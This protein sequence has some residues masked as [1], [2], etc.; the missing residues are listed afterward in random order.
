MVI[1][2]P[3]Q[4]AHRHPIHLIQAQRQSHW[5]PQGLVPIGKASGRNYRREKNRSEIAVAGINETG[6]QN[7]VPVSK[8]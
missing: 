3:F 1:E 7:F 4:M 5:I 6:E 8:H 2:G